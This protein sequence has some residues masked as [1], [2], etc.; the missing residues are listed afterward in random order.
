MKIGFLLATQ[1]STLAASGDRRSGQ[2]L[3]VSAIIGV[4]L[5]FDNFLCIDARSS[6]LVVRCSL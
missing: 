5:W 2:R 6:P 4:Y 3:S 1:S